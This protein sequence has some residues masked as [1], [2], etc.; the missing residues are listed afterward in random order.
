MAV[1]ERRTA[2]AT[3]TRELGVAGVH[4]LLAAVVRGGQLTVNFHPDR[5]CVDGRTVAAAL[6]EDGVYRSQ[7]VTG[8]SNG[9]LTAYPGGDR[10]RWEQ[11][12]FETPSSRCS[13]GS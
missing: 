2:T 5:L 8:I 4:D 11:R 13:P 1:A 7:F 12:M 3:I 6:F 10:D 9:G